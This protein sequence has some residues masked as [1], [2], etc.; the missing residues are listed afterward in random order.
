MKKK[1][2][3]KR[4][5]IEFSVTFVFITFFYLSPFQGFRGL[6]QNKVDSTQPGWYGRL[7]NRVDSTR[8]ESV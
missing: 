7:K 1:F 6:V 3:L 4:N 5:K 8:V 2:R